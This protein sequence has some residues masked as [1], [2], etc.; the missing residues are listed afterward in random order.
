MIESFT[1]ADSEESDS[2]RHKLLRAK[3][4]EPITTEDGHTVNNTGDTG[5]YKVTAWARDNKMIFNERKSKLIIIT[6]RRPKI[7]RD[8][9][10]YLNN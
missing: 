1:P 2:D 10:M 5:N 6:R 7:K 4:K 9:K 8:Y 3:I